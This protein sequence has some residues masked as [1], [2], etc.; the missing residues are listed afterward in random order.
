MRIC[1]QLRE[2]ALKRRLPQL[3]APASMQPHAE[4]MDQELDD[5]ARACAPGLFVDVSMKVFPLL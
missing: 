3:R 5:A 4:D 1:A 2:A